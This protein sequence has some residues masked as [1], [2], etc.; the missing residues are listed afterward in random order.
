MCGQLDRALNS[1]STGHVVNYTKTL[2]NY[3]IIYLLLM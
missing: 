3:K 1:G 2:N